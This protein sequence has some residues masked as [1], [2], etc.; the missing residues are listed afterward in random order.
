MRTKV[1]IRKLIADLRPNVQ[2]LKELSTK[3]LDQLLGLECFQSA[4]RVGLYMPLPDEIDVTPLFQNKEKAFYIP[5]FDDA[6]DGYRMAKWTPELKAGKFGIPEPLHPAWAE[7]EEL[8]LI[9]VPGMAFDPTG[10]RLGRGGGFYDRLLPQ[11]NATRAGV[12]FD[13]QCLE[14]IETE[15]HDCKMDVILT[16]SKFF[17]LIR[18]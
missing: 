1:E 4:N 17:E 6:C 12:C 11:Y 15:P 7:P 18:Q 13:F 14:K 3:V 10:N 2:T 5:A 9:L 8:D 16:E